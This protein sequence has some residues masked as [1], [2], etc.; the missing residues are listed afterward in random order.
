MGFQQRQRDYHVPSNQFHEFQGFLL[1]QRRKHGLD[2]NLHLREEVTE[3]NKV[4]DW[5]KYQSYKLREYERL[6]TSLKES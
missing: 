2:G 6:E 1:D 3:Q 5:M 4:D